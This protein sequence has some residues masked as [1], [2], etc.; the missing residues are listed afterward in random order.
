MLN[1][2]KEFTNLLTELKHFMVDYER[3][4]TPT[5]ISRLELLGTHISEAATAT[6]YA[7]ELENRIMP[8]QRLDKDLYL[9]TLKLQYLL[10][11]CLLK[12][13]GFVSDEIK[14][15]MEKRSKNR[16]W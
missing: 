16:P 1:G 2:T 14:T 7:R 12:E 5:R 11:T 3:L 9:I 6:E 15:V 10:E 4:D 13:V 8:I